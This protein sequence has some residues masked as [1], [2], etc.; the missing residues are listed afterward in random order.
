MLLDMTSRELRKL[1]KSKGCVEVRQTG[2]H[3]RIVCGKCKTTIPVHKGEDLGRGLLKAIE[4][5]L[6]PCLGDG[7]LSSD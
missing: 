1:L 6:A 5:Q 4:K 2:S 7:W 3:L